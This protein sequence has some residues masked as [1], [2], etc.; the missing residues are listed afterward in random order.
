[1]G[2]LGVTFREKPDYE[3]DKLSDEELI[4][5]VVAA[6]RAG[7]D[8]AAKLGL[9]IFA[10]RNFDL[11][12]GRA[13]AKPYISQAD[14]ED[15]AGQVIEAAFKAA[16]NGQFYGEAMAFLSRVLF[17]KVNDFYRK[18]HFTDSLP[19]DQDP[20]DRKGPAV[21]TVEDETDVVDLFD[22]VERR[23]ALLSPEHRLV[24]DLFVFDGHDAIETAAKVNKAFRELNP[25]M[26]DQNVHKIASRYR[27]DLRSDLEQSS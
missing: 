17:N 3:L 24:V 9:G 18:L 11:L 5:Y 22:V 19:E 15:I 14:A 16:F 25:P 21:A 8:A 7:N 2:F 13:R 20:E 6:R 27:K 12:V 23:S 26:S 1:L 4:A 10:H